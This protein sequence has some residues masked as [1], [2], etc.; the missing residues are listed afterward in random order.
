MITVT[1]L[2]TKL[3]R[4]PVEDVEGIRGYPNILRRYLSQRGDM[5]RDDALRY[6]AIT[7]C[8]RLEDAYRWAAD[9]A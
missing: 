5:S 8:H 1:V 9:V 4:C 6:W 3:D 7:G 2:P